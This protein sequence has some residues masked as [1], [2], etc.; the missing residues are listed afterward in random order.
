[1]CKMYPLDAQLVRSFDGNLV[2]VA[3]SVVGNTLSKI[4]VQYAT[5]S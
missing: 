4:V 2:R 3:V 1:M 5:P